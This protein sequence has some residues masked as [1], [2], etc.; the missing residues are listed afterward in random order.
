MAISL[1][2]TF[3]SATK[4]QK[5]ILLGIALPNEYQKHS[6][7][8]RIVKLYK[9]E[10]IYLFISSLITALPLFFITYTSFVILYMTLWFVLY[11]VASNHFFKINNHKLLLLKSHNRWFSVDNSYRVITETSKDPEMRKILGIAKEPLY[12]DE[13]EY[14]I[15]GYYYNPYDKQTMVD[16][17]FGYGMTCNMATKT[18]KILAYGGVLFSAVVLCSIL[19][20]FLRFD[21]ATFE[22]TVNE[23]TVELKAPVYSYEFNVND[24]EEISLEESLP[25]KGT[26]TNGAGTQTYLLGNFHYPDIG[27]SKLY[28]YRDYPPYIRIK[29]KDLT[30][31]FN[32][33]SVEETN[34]IYEQLIDRISDEH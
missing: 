26:R 12:V 1:F 30:V 18:G 4:P 23:N 22:L 28:V 19:L 31:L 14:W 20:L 32:T 27:R 33:K 34:E 3:Q 9:K 10:T 2:A 13:D 25:K 8:I 16:K 17:R 24:I 11:L 5:D 15:K 7:V 6:E 21:F 29:L